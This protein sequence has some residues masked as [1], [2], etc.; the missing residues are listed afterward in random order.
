MSKKIFVTGGTGFI[1]SHTILS[2]LQRGYDV[3]AYDSLRNSSFKSLE[4]VKEILKNDNPNEEIKLEF[5]K[6]DIRDRNLIQNIFE[7]SEKIGKEISAV[8]H[9]A[10]LKSVA[11]SIINPIDYWDVNVSGTINLLRI[12]QS[13]NCCKL[14]FSSSATVYGLSN[15]ETLKEE[16]KIDP[17]S[18][19]GF[20]KA[21]NE[22]FLQ[23]LYHGPLQEWSI[24]NLRYFNPI[25]AHESGKIGENPI[26]IPNNIFPLIN[27]VGLNIEKNIKVFG[28]DWN[29]NDGTCVRDYIDVMDLSEGHILALES[30]IQ[31]N[32]SFL[33]L[34]LG[35]GKGISVLNLIN[36]FEEANNI[37]IPYVFS[38][39]REGDR[40]FLVADNSKAK[41]ILN[42]SPKRNLIDTCR[43]GWKWFKNNPKGY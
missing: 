10:G 26:G 9:F 25:G 17:I 34:N 36:A 28:N 31:K 33:N 18:P 1:G 13:F 43:N 21:V 40:P 4:R 5:I 32:K 39:R 23:N 30:V 11:K 35:T 6:G 38:E 15:G 16:F 22:N 12:M 19:Y 24:C 20:T 29:T 41:R 37:K 3:I 2:L 8:I 27:Q 14:V 7:E 42:W